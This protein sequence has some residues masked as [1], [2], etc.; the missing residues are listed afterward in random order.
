MKALTCAAVRRRLDAFLDDELQ[1]RERIAVAAHLEWCG[2]CA[3]M[4]EDADIIGSALR[5]STRWHEGVAADE[6]G[7]LRRAIVNRAMAERGRSAVVLLKQLFQDWRP[8]YVGAGAFVTAVVCTLLAV[9]IV[10]LT[11][12]ENPES[13]AAMIDRLASPG[14]NGNPLK[15]GGRVPMPRA[16]DSPFATPSDDDAV[17][18]LSA[19]ITREGRVEDL[20]LLRACVAERSEEARLSESLMGAVSQARF[21]PA[22]LDGSPVAVRMVWVVAHTTVRGGSVTEQEVTARR[23]RDRASGAPRPPTPA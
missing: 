1:I 23:R 3:A 17:F 11:T 14:S 16:I 6:D 7:R 4:K 5:V 15:A 20:R 12:P 9:A 21:E 10:Q 19:V 8:V 2:A 22:K 18:A 13:L